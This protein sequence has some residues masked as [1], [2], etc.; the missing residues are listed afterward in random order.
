MD[1][2]KISPL[3]QQMM[4]WSMKMAFAG[5]GEKF[6]GLSEAFMKA[7]S[8]EF[9]YVGYPEPSSDNFNI[10]S[11]SGVRDAALLKKG[12]D[13]IIDLYRDTTVI[14]K[15]SQTGVRIQATPNAYKIGEVPVAVLDTKVDVKGAAKNDPA[16]A[17]MS[18]VLAMLGSSHFAVSSDLAVVAMG[19]DPKKAMA[20]WLDAKV[21]GGLDQAPGLA[22]A[23]AR[24]A[25]NAF[26]LA[27][28]SVQ[29]LVSALGTKGR[30]NS[31]ATT[32]DSG[33]AISLGSKNGALRLAIDVP[34]DQI[35][36][37]IALGGSLKG[38]H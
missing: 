31:V 25:D 10:V 18:S 8:G 16:L 36:Q 34:A 20:A 26:M 38:M 9:A 19:Q 35:Q 17:R 2:E 22:K 24:A 5:G 11:L 6:A 12:W 14:E 29:G 21:A 3:M 27:W 23:K 30:K 37:L 33:I 32:S 1:T 4:Q 28:G 7:C 13:D 15:M